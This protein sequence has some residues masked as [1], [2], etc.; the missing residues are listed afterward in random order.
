MNSRGVRLIEGEVVGEVVSSVDHSAGHKVVAE[1]ARLVSEEVGSARHL[2]C[3]LP[4]SMFR[5]DRVWSAET[6]F[7]RGSCYG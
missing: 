7:L 1:V 2:T 3:R 5:S 4:E 6:N